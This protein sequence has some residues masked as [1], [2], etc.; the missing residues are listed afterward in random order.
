[1]NIC[2][3][4]LLFVHPDMRIVGKPKAIIT[5][6]P[7]WMA[8]KNVTT[9]RSSHLTTFERQMRLLIYCLDTLFIMFRVGHPGFAQV[10]SCL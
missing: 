6:R 8:I 1:M 2:I 10:Y 9:A 4:V 7:L 3:L 5:G